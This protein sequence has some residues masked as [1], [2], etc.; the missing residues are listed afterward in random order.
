LSGGIRLL[1]L[2]EMKVENSSAAPGMY[3]LKYGLLTIATTIGGHA[4]CLDLNTKQPCVVMADHAFCSY[5]D[6]LKLVECVLVPDEIAESYADDEPIVLSYALI[7]Q[8]LPEIA[9]SYQDFLLKLS[10]ESYED[11]DF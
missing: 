10:N 4:I 5:N 1:D 9:A 6:D 2:E 11:M 3:L 7:K 8:C